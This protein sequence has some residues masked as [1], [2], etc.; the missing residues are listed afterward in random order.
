MKPDTL[1]YGFKI[2]PVSP[3]IAQAR[4]QPPA[5]VRGGQPG[6]ATVGGGARRANSY[7]ASERKQLLERC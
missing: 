3:G 1:E 6:I 5:L 7:G 4:P 2:L